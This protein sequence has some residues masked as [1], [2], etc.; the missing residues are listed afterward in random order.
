MNTTHHP[1]NATRLAWLANVARMA[2]YTAEARRV[3]DVLDRNAEQHPEAEALLMAGLENPN[4]R[5]CLDDAL[6]DVL[7]GL[8]LL[9]ET[10][11]ER[12]G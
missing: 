9:L 3:L 4:A 6:P 12:E 2:A 5:H 11:A 7:D 1:D 10:L 8:A